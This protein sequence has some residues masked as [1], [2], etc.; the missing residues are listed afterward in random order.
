MDINDICKLVHVP[1]KVIVNRKLPK[2]MI[3]NHISNL[4]YRSVIEKN[5]SEINIVADLKE[6]NSGI[7]SFESED[8]LY[9]EIIYLYV[10]INNYGNLSE[11]FNFL[12][13]IIPYPLVVIFRM[14]NDLIIY[15]GDYKRKKDD[16]LKIENIY[17]SDTLSALDISSYYNDDAELSKD[18]MKTYYLGVKEYFKM[19][20]IK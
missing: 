9:T 12:S 3:I 17:C 8:E 1:E 15:A 13:G 7:E 20:I 14:G 11:I 5:I 19:N 10:K 6:S 16:F 18:N 4:S 2:Y